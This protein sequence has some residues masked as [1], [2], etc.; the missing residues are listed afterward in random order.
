MAKK[1]VSP[2]ITLALH[3]IASSVGTPLEKKFVVSAEKPSSAYVCRKRIVTLHTQ[4]ARV[5]EHAK[6]FFCDVSSLP[7]WQRTRNVHAKTSLLATLY[8]LK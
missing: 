7:F 5:A 2:V 3:V 6:S 8:Q 1:I 4:M